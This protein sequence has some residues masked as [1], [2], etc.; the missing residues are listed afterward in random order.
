MTIKV[1]DTIKFNRQLAVTASG[2]WEER[3]V[4]AEG[5]VVIVG[6]FRERAICWVEIN[7]W[8]YLI[9][10]DSIVEHKEHVE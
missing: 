5:V 2:A 7:E 10:Q 3:E 1:R 6:K 8:L 4:E 9:P